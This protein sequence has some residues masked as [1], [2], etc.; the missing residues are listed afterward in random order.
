ML[1]I[2]ILLTATCQPGTD[3]PSGAPS[4]LVPGGMT[5]TVRAVFDSATAAYT[6]GDLRLAHHLFAETIAADSLLA[7]AW[8]GLSL[9]ERAMGRVQGRDTA[10]ERARSL[11]EPPVR[12]RGR[13]AN[14]AT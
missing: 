5:T 11:I 7:A 10:L 13:A 1:A 2:A 12:P 4:A 9:V 8:V 14:P 3:A 6:A